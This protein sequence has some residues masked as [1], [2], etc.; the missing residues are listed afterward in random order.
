MSENWN[1]ENPIAATLEAIVRGAAV[2]LTPMNR[3]RRE[4]WGATDEELARPLPGDELLPKMRWASTHAIGIA[5]PPEAVWPWVAQIGHGRGGFYS[6]EAL[7]NLL[8]CRIHN[9]DTILPDFQ[10]PRP[11]DIIRMHPSD[12]MPAFTVMAVDAPH[13]F[14]LGNPPEY[15]RA[16]D[17]IIGVSWLFHIDPAPMNSSRLIVRWRAYY[18]PDSLANRVYFGPLL[19]EQ[20]SFVME[21]KMLEGIKKRAESLARPERTPSDG[22]YLMTMA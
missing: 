9:A 12:K 5:A 6:Y 16:L 10:D 11:G 15:D 21:T 22:E 14:L 17:S 8:G 19:V 18:E 4:R 1:H 7:E 20:L 2:M 3:Q 13:D